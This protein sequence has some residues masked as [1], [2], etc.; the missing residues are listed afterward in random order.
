METGYTYNHYDYFATTTYFFDDKTPS[1]VRQREYFGDIHIGMAVTNAGKLSFSTSYAF[2]NSTYYQNNMFSRLDTAD[3]TSFNFVNPQFC[4]ELNNLNRKQYASAGAFFRLAL[5]Y[6]N[7]NE[8]FLPGTLSFNK[9]EFKAN[10]SWFYIK[11]LYDNYFASWGPFKFGFYTEAHISNQPLLN[12]YTSTILNVP[13]FQPVPEMQTLMI[14]AFRATSFAGLGFKTVLTLY[15]K[16]EFRL[17]GYVFQPYQE[18]TENPL[19]HTALPGAVLSDRAWVGSA[20]LVYNTLIGPI[21]LGINYYDKKAENFTLNV[22]I[23]Y[24]LF[25]RKALP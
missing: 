14:P 12:N 15:K 18:I 6:I 25:N 11:L 5:G 24:M 2:N 13:D 16:V 3:Q 9:K 7:G 1:Y 23:G 19:D 22:N 21:S 8:G 4:F 10:H 20:A 17:E